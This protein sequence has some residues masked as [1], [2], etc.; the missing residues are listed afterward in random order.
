MSDQA[1]QFYVAETADG[2]FVA[3]TTRS[4]YFCFVEAS[5]DGAEAIGHRAFDLAD[6]ID[7]D[8]FHEK[9]V[10][11]TVTD[12]TPTRVVRRRQLALAD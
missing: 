11:R 12:L 7:L 6:K 2:K 1:Q 3:Y 5:E 10:S 8:E 4:P 9:S